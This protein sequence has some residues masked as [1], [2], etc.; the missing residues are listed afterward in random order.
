MRHIVKL[1]GFL[2]ILMIFGCAWAQDVTP[3][4][5]ADRASSAVVMEALSLIGTPYRYAGDSPEAGFDCSGFVSFVFQDALDRHLPHSADEIFHAGSK[6]HRDELRAG[7]VLFFHIGHH[8]HKINHVALYIGDGQFVHA[9]TSGSTV[10]VDKLS[11]SYWQRYYRGARRLINDQV[12]LLAP[13]SSDAVT[14]G[15]SL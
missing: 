14:T 7:D 8:G 2:T 9:P 4:S 10:R 12:A 1:T 3:V 11:D 15:A 5:I 6:V 13:I